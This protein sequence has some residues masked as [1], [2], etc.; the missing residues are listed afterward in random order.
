M[1]PITNSAITMSIVFFLVPLFY[2]MFH[3]LSF[4]FFD[5]LDLDD[6]KCHIFAFFTSLFLMFLTYWAF[7]YTI[8]YWITKFST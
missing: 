5:Y 1:L 3:F 7:D 4:K 8:K 2:F 6:L